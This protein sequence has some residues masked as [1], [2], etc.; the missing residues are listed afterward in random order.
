MFM[1]Y[2]F[3]FNMI[4]LMYYVVYWLIFIFSIYKIKYV[5]GYGFI[6]LNSFDCCFIKILY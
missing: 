1:N 5:K 4:Y 2:M 3:L 6:K